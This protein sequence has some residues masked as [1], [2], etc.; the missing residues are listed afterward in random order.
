MKKRVENI[1]NNLEKK[2]D[3]II[4][5]NSSEPFIDNNFF[6]VTGLDKGMFEGSIAILR[7][8]GKIDLIVSELEAELAKKAD[9]NINMYRSKEEFDE[10]LKAFISPIKN[11]GINFI[12]ILHRD[13]VKLKRI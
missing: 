3:A 12:G 1:F 8:D 10:I 11:I 4:I 9:V 6:Y 5:K 13:F 2:P 7:P